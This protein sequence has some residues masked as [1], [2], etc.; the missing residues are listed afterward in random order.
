MSDH[1]DCGCQEYNEL[2]RRSFVAGAGAALAAAAFPAWL[3]RVVL[4]ESY[5]ST[6]DVIVSVFMRGGADGLSLVV[7][8]GDPDYYTARPTLNIAPPD[9]AKTSKVTALT[10]YFGLPP[11]LT[12]LVPAYKA[13]QLLVVHAAGVTV[14]NRSHFD[15]QRFIEVGKANDPNLITGWLGRHLASVPPVRTSAPLRA[16]GLADGL[17]RTLYGA[18]KTLPIADPST[19]GIS[20]SATTAQAR[21]D[22]LQGDYFLTLE[23]VRSAALDA[24]NT[25]A[26]LRNVNVSGYRPANGATYPNSA[27]G[28]SLRSAAALIK[29]DVG[30]EAVQVDIG[31][32]D[33]HQQQDPNAGSMFRTMGDFAGALGAF[34]SDV[35]APGGAQANVTLVALSEFGRNVREN[36]SLG[37][38]H[39]RAGAMF[40]MGPGI[41]GGRVLTNNWPGLARENLESGQDLKV[42]LDHR[43]ILAEIVAKR[44]GNPSVDVVFPEYRP[45]FRGVA[46]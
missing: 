17:Q 34:W 3:P 26:L 46:S 28:R 16:L 35:M 40:V 38:D 6:R 11:A 30:I 39:G 15:M 43:D 33:T 31:G 2:S 18:P 24:T 9:S 27:F 10:N 19:Y 20:G 8:F 32:W 14:A 44:L 5:V 13:G 45:T 23:P 25:L 7:P 12:P 37:T 4:A 1:L 21:A 29:A 22:F 36:A 42:T 41:V